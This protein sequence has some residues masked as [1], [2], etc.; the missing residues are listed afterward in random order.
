MSLRLKLIA[1]FVLFSLLP[2]LLLGYTSYSTVSTSLEQEIRQRQSQWANSMLQDLNKSIEERRNLLKQLSSLPKIKS[3]SLSEQKPLLESF[4]SVFPDMDAIAVI[5]MTGMQTARSN[6]AANVNV[7]DRDYTRAILKEGKLFAVGVPTISKVTG[8]PILSIAVP[9]TE[10]GQLVG[11]LAGYLR[12]DDVIR[13]FITRTQEFDSS[14]DK[15]I[16]IVDSQQKLLY[17]PDNSKTTE[18]APY[19]LPAAGADGTADYSDSGVRYVA[20]LMHSDFTNLTIL[21]RDDEATLFAPIYKLTYLLLGLSAGMIALSLVASTLFGRRIAAPLEAMG[22]QARKLASGD[23]T[24]HLND[25][26]YSEPEIRQLV[27][28]FQEMSHGLQQLIGEIQQ[29]SR[30]VNTESVSLNGTCQQSAK[31]ADHLARSNE[32]VANTL[33]EQTRH[34]SQTV[35]QMEQLS[36]LSQDIVTEGK[37]ASQEGFQ[38]TRLS[39]T[40]STSLQEAQTLSETT[41]ETMRQGAE[42]TS[43]LHEKSTGIEEIIQ[44]IT[45]ITDQTNL[46]ALNAAIEAARAGEHGLGFGVVADEIRK[47]AE[48][49]RQAA[50][51]IQ[52]II[53]EIRTDIDATV[54]AINEGHRLADAEHQKSQENAARLREMVELLK[55]QLRRFDS[56]I[57]RADSQVAMAVTASTSLQLL[58]EKATEAA[59]STQAVTA[60]AQEVA[61]S[62]EEVAASADKLM[63]VAQSSQTVVERFRLNG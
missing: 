35:E 16:I 31:A 43:Q 48:Q 13:S 37:T 12:V 52:T 60:I 41:A 49:S 55:G 61:A 47:L 29:S 44:A 46:L 34:L 63:E 36:I 32:A 59:S 6:S 53:T 17:H 42:T 58:Y 2:L 27:D 8:K 15:K 38:L 3:M 40:I 7:A 25:I 11:A 23:L 56:V 39:E 18:T 50:Q 54:S 33:L 45:D 5:D 62:S 14:A 9:I 30:L 22:A 4:G 51:R 26:N 1:G 28:A 21:I 19:P 24:V 10:G 57:E 20:T